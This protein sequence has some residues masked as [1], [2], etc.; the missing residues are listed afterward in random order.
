[1]PHSKL[2]SPCRV[3]LEQGPPLELGP[4]AGNDCPLNERRSVWGLW[5]CPRDSQS[6]GSSE[7]AREDGGSLPGQGQRGPGVRGV[8]SGSAAE[9][10]LGA[11]LSPQSGESRQG[12]LCSKGAA[13]RNT[14][15][16]SWHPQG[17][18]RR[19]PGGQLPSAHAG[20][21]LAL[22][23]DTVPPGIQ[24]WHGA[25]WTGQWSG[26]SQSCPRPLWTSKNSSFRRHE[27]EI[28]IQGPGDPP[29]STQGYLQPE[30]LGRGVRQ[31][32]SGR[33]RGAAF[34]VAQR[35]GLI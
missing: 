10:L 6:L 27:A 16:L 12:H 1:M 25:H 34:P 15:A 22:R 21:G 8:L 33:Q 14:C 13:L 28:Q 5:G 31:V 18:A 7:A 35:L 26:P 17:P 32:S 2:T 3:L 29:P 30:E 20:T 4:A 23:L 24:G 11:R 19:P 9:G